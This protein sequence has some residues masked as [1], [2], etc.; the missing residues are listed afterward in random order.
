MIL[1]ITDTIRLGNKPY[2]GWCS[3]KFKHYIICIIKLKVFN[4][5]LYH[6]ETL[7]NVKKCKNFLVTLMKLASSGT[8]SANMAQNVRA[9]VKGLLVCPSL[10]S[11]PIYRIHHNTLYV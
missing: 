3:N 1:V 11:K 5:N 6:Q 7:E 9:L 10:L 8:R 4:F 2:I